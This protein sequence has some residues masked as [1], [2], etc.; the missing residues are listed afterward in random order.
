MG[1]YYLCMLPRAAFQTVK[2]PFK[3]SLITSHLK[4]LSVAILHC[5]EDLVTRVKKENRLADKP[6]KLQ[7]ISQDDINIIALVPKTTLY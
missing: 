6:P 1:K 5:N 2:F 4:Q 7:P 3:T